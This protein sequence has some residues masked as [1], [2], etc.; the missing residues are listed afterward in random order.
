MKR[1]RYIGYL[2]FLSFLLIGCGEVAQN[3]YQMNQNNINVDNE[4]NKAENIETSSTNEKEKVEKEGIDIEAPENPTPTLSA[5]SYYSQFIGCKVKDLPEAMKNTARVSDNSTS[6][7][8]EFTMEDVAGKSFAN[9]YYVNTEGN[10]I[11]M[12]FGDKYQLF[13]GT[14]LDLHKSKVI[15]Q[16]YSC[17]NIDGVDFLIRND[18]KKLISM[19]DAVIVAYKIVGAS[20]ADI[21]AMS[22]NYK[23]YD[24]NKE[25]VS[26]EA[27]EQDNTIK[28]ALVEKAT[29]ENPN[30]S[31]YF[32]C[33]ECTY[34][35]QDKESIMK[36]KEL[37]YS[38]RYQETYNYNGN[39][40]EEDSMEID[41]LDSTYTVTKTDPSDKFR[42]SLRYRCLSSPTEYA[43]SEHGIAVYLYDEDYNDIIRIY[44]YW[45]NL[46]T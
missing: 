6:V 44:D 15:A 33:G 14:Y 28:I 32:Y 24:K 4:E 30:P 5:L 41:L 36:D 9:S 22:D 34:T 21:R 13:K 17:F 7:L 19:E 20:E 45:Q 11:F 35:L 26:F 1:I 10:M 29:D 40:F 39:H 42:I 43:P 37:F 38:E 3:S 31:S 12:D 2:V 25:Y 46:T 27:E 16:G 18:S 8:W 23:I